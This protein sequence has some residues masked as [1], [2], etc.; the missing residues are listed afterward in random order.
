VAVFPLRRH[1]KATSQ[2]SERLSAARALRPDDFSPRLATRL[3]ILQATPFC[4]IDCDYCYLPDRNS[5]ARMEI[6]TVT[7]AM[8]RLLEDG[9]AGPQLTVVW[10]AGEPLAL[11]P[12]YYEQAFDALREAAGDGC[13]ISHSIQTNATLIDDRWCDLLERPDVRLGISLDG[14]AAIHDL[15]RKTRAGKGTHAA[16]MRG[17]EALQRRGVPFHVIAV[18]TADSL[19]HPDEIC[20]FYVEHGMR[21]VGFNFDEAE[22]T[23]EHS[24]LLGDEARHRAFIEAMLGH[25][26]RLGERYRVRELGYAFR[27]IA[28]GLPRYAWHGE[29]FPDNAQTMPF[30]VVTVAWNG[31]FSTFSPELLGQPNAAFGNFIL[32]NVARGSYLACT[33]GEAFRRLWTEVRQGV[34]EC[35]RSCAYFDYCGGGAPANKLYENGTLASSETLYCRAMIQRPFDAVLGRLESDLEFGDTPRARDPA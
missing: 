12:R 20:R 5:R 13:D 34:G 3:L 22:G 26:R 2:S 7:L 33:G 11:P 1:F 29:R 10:H 35:Q 18:A 32:G 15:H 30:A 28:E 31:D 17:V 6:E 24:S 19:A 23:H 4:N 9:L 25:S 16:V 27:V 21:E 14:P 8:R